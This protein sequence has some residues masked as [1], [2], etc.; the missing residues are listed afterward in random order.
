MAEGSAFGDQ[1]VDGPLFPS[2]GSDDGGGASDIE[3]RPDDGPSLVGIVTTLVDQMGDLA[4]PPP[5]P[6]TS[7]R[8]LDE[9]MRRIKA[10]LDDPA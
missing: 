1:G 4:T 5:P 7:G 2:D 9:V 8:D 3:G 10:I 6:K